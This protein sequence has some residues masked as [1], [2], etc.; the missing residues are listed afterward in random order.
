MNV[1]SAKRGKNR[2]FPVLLVSLITNIILVSQCIL[3]SVKQDQ[4]ILMPT[5]EEEKT[6]QPAKNN[7]NSDKE[8]KFNNHLSH[9]KG[10]HPVWIYSNADVAKTEIK[11]RST[12]YR[13]HKL[14]Q[15]KDPYSQVNQ[16][17]VVLALTDAH[18]AKVEES[19]KKDRNNFFIDLAANDAIVLSNTL[20][21]EQKG[22]DGICIEGNPAYWYGLG[23]YR[24]CTVIGAFVGG[25]GSEADGA[26]VDISL[27]GVGG[28]IV[29]RGMDN[30][31]KKAKGLVKRELVS[32][33]T[34]LKEA[35]APQSIDY[36]S[37]DV[38][39]AETLVM[40][41]FPWEDY[42]FRFMTIERPKDDL[43]E[44]LKSHGYRE[45]KELVTWGETLWVHEKSVNLSQDEMKA[46]I[47]NIQ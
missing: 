46:I 37:L 43:K 21:L 11:D 45:V 15:R 9:E 17:M 4:V 35:N 2:S 25:S 24:K 19:Q 29:G 42:T 39:G 30:K 44:L 7:N 1:T 26:V 20:H 6:F 22:W 36:F 18:Y 33:S 47:D 40:K 34:V 38:E 3:K 8:L 5:T 31:N 27:I 32:I 23:R 14:G 28:G 13:P 10:F 41:D 12:V 16:D